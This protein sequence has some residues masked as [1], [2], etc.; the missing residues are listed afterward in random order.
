MGENMISQQRRLVS[1]SIFAFVGLLMF[2]GVARA[3]LADDR[4]D[5]FLSAL[6]SNRLSS[7]EQHCSPAV[8]AI[9]P[10]VQDVWSQLVAQYGSLKSFNIT[11]RSQVEGQDLR[12]A[13]LKF[14]HS[15][16][17]EAQVSIDGEGNVSG[18]YFV[19][20]AANAGTAV[21]AKA[22][23]DRVNQM[24]AALRENNFSAAEDHFDAAMKSAFPPKALEDEWKKRADPIGVLKSWRIVGRA[25]GPAGMQIR[26]VNL[27]FAQAPKAFALRL[28][29]DSAG[30]IGG[31]Y[32]VETQPETASTI[33]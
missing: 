10:K 26:L 13:I 21:S 22:A 23:D 15:D 16:A 17:F 4:T 11:S 8:R 25:D 33:P 5:Q 7:V 6:Q 28:G 9:F 19:P 2:L 3:D 29:I 32:F 30:D 14:E 20:A 31:F 27:A 18:I 1:I 12:I 24:L